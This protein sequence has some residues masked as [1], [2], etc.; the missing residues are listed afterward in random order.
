M[1]FIRFETILCYWITATLSLPSAAAEKHFPYDRPHISE[2]RGEL[3]Q[4]N[5][6]IDPHV[7]EGIS[8]FVMEQ[9]IFYSGYR[10]IYLLRDAE[11]MFDIDWLLWSKFSDKKA[12]DP[13][14]TVLNL[15]RKNISDPLVREYLQQEGLFSNAQNIVLIDTGFEGS[16]INFVNQLRAERGLSKL[17]S[18]LISSSHEDSASSRIASVPYLDSV[19]SQKKYTTAQK[20]DFLDLVD[21]QISDIEGL[22]KFNKTSDHFVRIGNKILPSSQSR[23]SKD[24]VSAAASIQRSVYEWASRKSTIMLASK[25]ESTL[26]PLLDQL[27]PTHPGLPSAEV[28]Q[29]AK[30][31]IEKHHL[32]WFWQDLREAAAKGRINIPQEKLLPLWNQVFGGA[33]PELFDL[34]EDQRIIIEKHEAK[35][36]GAVP[37]LQSVNHQSEPASLIDQLVQMRQSLSRD[38]KLLRSIYLDTQKMLASKSLTLGN[39]TH[40][41]GRKIGS[42]VRSDVYELG[43]TMAL[44]VAGSPEDIPYL[45]VEIEL[46]HLLNNYFEGYDI[47]ALPMVAFDPNSGF[48]VRDRIRK[49]D[50]G[51]SI[52]AR[53]LSSRKK[54]KLRLL[55]EN[56]RSFAKDHGVGLD[57]KPDNIAWIDDRWVVFD[58]GPRTSYGPF[59]FTLDLRNFEEFLA[60]WTYDEPRKPSKR[61]GTVSSKASPFRWPCDPRIFADIHTQKDAP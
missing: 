14:P 9:R 57:L 56:A 21:M 38:K 60:L 10:R 8:N 4:S 51:S 50:L 2:L 31:T 42:G 46:N 48:I 3:G 47:A 13:E 49:E 35:K 23:S 36:S 40:R 45:A 22:P 52:E 29:T 34:E 19:E 33:K 39:K 18:H 15:S 32:E 30:A 26:G 1:S 7:L 11:L 27:N 59:A 28:I 41:I 43:E 53:G 44:K 6:A 20:E 58:L 17:R 25:L 12:I 24:D 61:L 16:I 5:T 54:E 37:D 55:F